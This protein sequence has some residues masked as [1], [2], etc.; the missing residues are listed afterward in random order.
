MPLHK[1]GDKASC[2]NYCSIS[3]IYPLGHLSTKVSE[4]RLLG[5][6]NATQ[7]IS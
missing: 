7:A 2:D 6:P 4:Y 5:D 3:L 1:K